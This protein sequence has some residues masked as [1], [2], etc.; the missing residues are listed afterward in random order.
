MDFTGKEKL[1][2]LGYGTVVRHLPGICKVLSSI[3]STT[4]RSK[5]DREMEMMETEMIERGNKY[6]EGR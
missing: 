5:V 6:R 4:K 3:P 1:G 2:D